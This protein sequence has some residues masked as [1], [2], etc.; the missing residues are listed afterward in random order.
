M[1]GLWAERIPKLKLFVYLLDRLMRWHLPA[2]HAHFAWMQL[3]PE[4]LA[5]QWFLTLFAYNMPLPILLTLFDYIF[6]TGW[7]GVY[8]LSIAVLYILQPRL[9]EVRDM[10]GVAVFMKR[11][12][13]RNNYHR[14]RPL[15]PKRKPAASGEED[16]PADEEDLSE[17]YH[18]DN[19]APAG[20]CDG[21]MEDA[22]N[23]N[24][25]QLLMRG[26]AVSSMVNDEVLSKLQ[27][28][29]AYELIALAE[30]RREEQLAAAAAAAG[31]NGNGNFSIS[32]GTSSSNSSTDTTTTTDGQTVHSEDY[33]QRQQRNKDQIFKEKG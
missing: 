1:A 10:E 24:L 15:R 9:L 7:S 17:K 29:Y 27:E 19:E 16:D 13:I 33:I 21:D 5:T 30:L 14:R 3:S 22:S 23:I 12:K 6:I 25:Q 4:V 11:W 8:I 28:A 2:L 26:K 18:D 31:K 32:T 20:R